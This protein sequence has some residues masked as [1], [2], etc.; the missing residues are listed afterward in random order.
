MIKRI[1]TITFC[2]IM[3][4]AMSM[5][6]AFMAAR[7]K[8]SSNRTYRNNQY[9]GR[10]GVT[11]KKLRWAKK[12]SY[13]GIGHCDGYVR[14]T[15]NR[16]YK[17]RHNFNNRGVRSLKNELERYSYKH[18]YR[19]R[20]QKKNARPG[21]IVVFYTG[22]NGHGTAYHIAVMGTNGKL[23][24]ATSRGG[25]IYRYSI[26]TMLAGRSG[27]DGYSVEIIRM[28]HKNKAST[29]GSMKL[30]LVT[31]DRKFVSQNKDVYSMKGAKFKVINSKGHTA[32]TITFGNKTSGKYYVVRSRK[33]MPGTYRLKQVKAAKNFGKRARTFRFR[34]TSQHK[35]Y[36]TVRM[37]PKYS[38]DNIRLDT[39]TGSE[40]TD[41][42]M[43]GAEY[44]VSWYS[45]NSSS[46]A[47]TTEKASLSWTVKPVKD[48]DGNWVISTS[49]SSLVSG[50][51]HYV[52]GSSSTHF[53]YP[54][55]YITIEQTK[56]P[57]GEEPDSTVYKVHITRVNGKLTPVLEKVEAENAADTETGTS[58]DAD[59]TSDQ[60]SDTADSAD[61]TD[62]AA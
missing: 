39:L 55:G 15:V 2:S 17:I 51:P 7:S 50:S 43:N 19:N 21:D 52:D 14:K 12:K 62:N 22:K 30:R 25:V 18:Y 16:Y 5:P 60:S 48:A 1:A 44:K 8:S 24:H 49:K 9:W 54:A 57:D 35:T 45:T 42:Q 58:D 53:V 3:I 34:V 29:Y 26:N 13:S 32:A 56:A 6:T 28:I 27:G 31:T 10:G 59:S 20:G 41:A 38:K 46:A 47:G 33:L 37:T 23:H 40:K 61:T 4:L 11:D 36:L